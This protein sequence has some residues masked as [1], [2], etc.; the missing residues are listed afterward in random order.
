M[1]VFRQLYKRFLITSLMKELRSQVVQ[2]GLKTI[3]FSNENSVIF[4]KILSNEP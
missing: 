3:T 2:L 1:L 4:Q